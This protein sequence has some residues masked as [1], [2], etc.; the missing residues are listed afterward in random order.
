MSSINTL[1]PCGAMGF[2]EQLAG[3]TVIGC[4]AFVLELTT[5]TL[6]AYALCSAGVHEERAVSIGVVAGN[7][8]SIT[9]C[10]IGFILCQY[11]LVAILIMVALMVLTSLIPSVLCLVIDWNKVE[12]EP[13]IAQQTDLQSVSFSHIFKQ[14]MGAF[15]GKRDQS[16]KNQDRCITSPSVCPQPPDHATRK[17]GNISEHSTIH[18]LQQRDDNSAEC[19]GTGDQKNEE[20]QNSETVAQSS[21]RPVID[22]DAV[23]SP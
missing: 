18:T 13:S 16:K 2:W 5:G 7:I 17:E 22:S 23:V 1:P 19:L 20:D 10:I 8:A 15:F 4:C 9:L 14:T 3:C 11:G 21:L 12:T 6:V